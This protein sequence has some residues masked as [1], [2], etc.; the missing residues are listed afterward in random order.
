ME[1]DDKGRTARDGYIHEIIGRYQKREEWEILDDVR[2]MVDSIES[3]L[4]PIS[5]T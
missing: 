2:M 4:R 5:T 1:L 3:R